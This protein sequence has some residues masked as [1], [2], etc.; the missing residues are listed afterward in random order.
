[1]SDF[2]GV[3]GGGQ[4]GADVEELADPGLADVDRRIF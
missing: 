1:L 3:V 2:V 4:L